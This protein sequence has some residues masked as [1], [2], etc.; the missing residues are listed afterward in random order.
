MKKLFVL[1]ASLLL[2]GGCTNITILDENG[3]VSVH[4]EFGFVTLNASPDTDAIVA[5]M[6]SLGYMASPIGVSVGYGSHS[7]ALLPENCRVVL[8][9]KNEQDLAE[10]KSLVDDIPSICP[11]VGKMNQEKQHE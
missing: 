9:V 5:E 2:F 10:F 1:L 7:V 4:R 8:W 3:T 6:T 11:I